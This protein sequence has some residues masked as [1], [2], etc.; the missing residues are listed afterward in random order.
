MI[1]LALRDKD[2]RLRAYGL[3]SLLRS[4]KGLLPNVVSPELFSELINK[5]L[6]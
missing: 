3:E 1:L 5:Q 4:E 6:K 2:A